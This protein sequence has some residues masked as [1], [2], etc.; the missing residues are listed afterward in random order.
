MP[1]ART[2]VEAEREVNDDVIYLLDFIRGSKR[3]VCFGK[4]MLAEEPDE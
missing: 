2:H 4:G 1:N 3:G